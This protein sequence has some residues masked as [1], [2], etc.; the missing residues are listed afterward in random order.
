VP[1][2]FGA[3]RHHE[4]TTAR[5]CCDGMLHLAAHRTHENV[6]LVQEVDHLARHAETGDEDG[7]TTFDH[8]LDAGVHLVR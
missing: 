5:H 6:L 7:S 3:L 2:C 1:A 4:I 8:C